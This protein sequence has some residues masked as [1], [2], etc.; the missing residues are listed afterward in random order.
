MLVL[1]RG[2]CL[3]G[4]YGNDVII[5]WVHLMS[6]AAVAILNTSHLRKTPPVPFQKDQ[7]KLLGLLLLCWLYHM[8]YTLPNNRWFGCC[9][10]LWIW[11]LWSFNINTRT[12][13]WGPCSELNNQLC[14]S[15][16]YRRGWEGG[17]N[18]HY[19][20]VC[21]Y[22]KKSGLKVSGKRVLSCLA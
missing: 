10:P 20:H 4:N 9:S 14:E 6:V 15:L 16:T 8:F 21:V 19:M 2:E 22:I 12:G 17:W 7:K 1:L 11:Q 5:V 13:S 18:V 3:K